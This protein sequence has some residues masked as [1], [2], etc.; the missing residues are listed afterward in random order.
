MTI[1]FVQAGP[2]GPVKIGYAVDP[3]RRIAS[4]QTACA[5]DLVL[6]REIAGN[7]KTE[8]W[9]HQRF[10]GHR[11]RGEWFSFTDDML[12]CEPPADADAPKPSTRTLRE[13]IPEKPAT[14]SL[15]DLAIWRVRMFA[16]AHAMAPSRLAVDAGLALNT[17]RGFNTPN[18]N[19][20]ASTLR[21]LEA[22]V[23]A[24]FNPDAVMARQPRGQA[25]ASSARASAAFSNSDPA[26]SAGTFQGGA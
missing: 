2:D 23:P 20:V 13:A 18:W 25:A 16:W 11:V 12:V 26:A 8:A 7:E 21:R 6:L 5:V 4:L 17:L 3:K 1:Y 19:P 14:T 24:N 22:V 10:L 15:I 9:L